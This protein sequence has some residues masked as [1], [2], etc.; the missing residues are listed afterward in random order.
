[1]Q[2]LQ[3][4]RFNKIWG[5]EL[6]LACNLPQAKN[7]ATPYP[8]LVKV[9]K[10]TDTLSVQ[11]H[12]DDDAAKSLEDASSI[13]KT[14]CWYILDAAPQ[15]KL[16]YGLKSGVTKDFLASAIQT[17]AIESC[18]N[19]VPIHK[20]DFIFIPSGSVHAI[21]AGITLLEVQQSCDITYRLYDYNRGRPLDI[22]KA[23]SSIKTV[24]LP[25]IK[26][27]SL[28][29]SCAYFTLNQ[30]TFNTNPKDRDTPNSKKQT[31]QPA[32]TFPTLYFV[33]S[34]N[35]AITNGSQSITLSPLDAILAAPSDNPLITG[36]LQLMKIDVP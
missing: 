26:Q 6:W 2:K 29:F 8:L 10:S 32:A 28:T 5:Y 11:V 35:G 13:G 27:F 17:G 21:G 15:S 20:G 25:D 24:P 3:P 18:L 30:L 34:G 9:I 23:L 14:E 22:K 33:I 1:M 12:P 4:I 16:I 19:S 36:N 31:V 7:I